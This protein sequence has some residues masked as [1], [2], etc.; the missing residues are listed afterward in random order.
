MVGEGSS[1]S[2]GVVYSSVPDLTTGYAYG[3][4]FSGDGPTME[5]YQGQV[6][7]PYYFEPI[8]RFTLTK[9]ANIDRVNLAVYDSYSPSPPDFTMEI[10][11]S[12]HSA[13]EFSQLINPSI[14][15][16]NNG[17]MVVTGSV[18]N[19]HL[20]AGTYW[21]GFYNPDFMTLPGFSTGNGS[22]IETEAHTGTDLGKLLPGLFNDV[23][24]NL[25]YQFIDTAVPE[26]TSWALLILGIAMVGIAARRRA[27]FANLT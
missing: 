17:E 24:G 1:A 9:T 11:N 23:G 4:W 10:Y 27:A 19:L 21:V 16:N 12:A 6:Y 3:A 22:L 15:T 5:F 2:A 14:L 18:S 20:A 8:D 13:I 26:P 25:G 7:G